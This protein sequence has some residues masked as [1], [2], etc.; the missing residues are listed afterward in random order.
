MHFRDYIELRKQRGDVIEIDQEVHWNLE[1][2]AI[3]ALN[4]RNWADK[5]V[6]LFNNIKGYPGKRLVSGLFSNPW[7]K[8]WQLYAEVVGL[9]P[10]IGMDEF[11]EQV[12]RKIQERI[13]PTVVSTGPCK[14]NILMGEE[15]NLLAFPFPYLHDGDG[16]RYGT[17]QTWIVKDPDSPWV[18]YGNY[19]M[20]IHSRY[21]AGS[22]LTPGQHMADIFYQK[23]EARGNTMPCCVAIG[24]DPAIMLVSTMPIPRGISEVDVAGSFAGEPIELVRAETNDLLVPAHAE[25]VIEGEFRP[26]ERMDEGPFGEYH[27]FQHGPRTPMPVMRVNCIT[28]RNNPIIPFTTEGMIGSESVEG[29]IYFW[30]IIVEMALGMAGYPI[31]RAWMQKL[32]NFAYLPLAI[33]SS[34]K[35]PGLVEDVQNALLGAIHQGYMSRWPVFDSDIEVDDLESLIEHLFLKTHPSKFRISKT[36]FG[37]AQ[38][39][40]MFHPPGD[41]EKGLMTYLLPDC[42]WPAHWGP[43]RIPK[44]PTLEN[45]Y[46]QEV[47]DWLRA[48]WKRLGFEEEPKLR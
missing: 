45:S 47:L 13:P 35:Y 19:R 36:E 31:K 14:E 44:K 26:G 16:G 18:N 5:K 32:I 34:R 21:K 38:E 25:I 46:P 23:Y 12:K 10:D 22:F 42:T 11:F 48:S 41:K 1:A 17:L 6:L 39:Q 28:F 43:D 3:T 33:D 8:P 30:G 7:E 29:L 15:V 4:Y 9:P 40:A 2:A 27:G 37:M 24:V 20:E